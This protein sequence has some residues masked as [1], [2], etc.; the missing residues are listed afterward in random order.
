MV[1]KT[2]I[3]QPGPGQ[4]YND[5]LNEFGKNATTFSIRGKPQ[6][7]QRPNI[8]GPGQYDPNLNVLKDKVR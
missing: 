3:E 7:Q 1:S 8:P 2:I 4:Y 5:N 6:E